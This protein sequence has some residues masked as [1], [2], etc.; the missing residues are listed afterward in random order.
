MKAVVVSRKAS[1]CLTYLLFKNRR[2]SVELLFN[3]VLEHACRKVQA[4]QEPEI[5]WHTSVSGVF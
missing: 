2:C 4:N 5:N 1:I 3:F